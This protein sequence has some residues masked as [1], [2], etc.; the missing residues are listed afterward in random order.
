MCCYDRW[1]EDHP[2]RCTPVNSWRRETLAS[3]SKSNFRQLGRCSAINPSDTTVNKIWNETK[4][5]FCW[6]SQQKLHFMSF[7]LDWN[8]CHHF[9]RKTQEFLCSSDIFTIIPAWAVWFSSIPRK[10]ICSNNFL[11]CSSFLWLPSFNSMSLYM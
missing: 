11:W 10:V 9:E 8:D 5:S 2:R 3:S 7:W 4:R 1:S 6:L